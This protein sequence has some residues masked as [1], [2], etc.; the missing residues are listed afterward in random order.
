MRSRVIAIWNRKGGSGKTTTAVNLAAALA[1]RG[2][3]VLLVD[4][5]PQGNASLWIGSRSDGSD[6]LAVLA[7]GRP[8]APLLQATRAPGV[9]LVPGGPL[10][11]QAESVLPSLPGADRR[12]Q[13]ALSRLES[14]D[15]VLLDTPPA[16]GLLTANALE[17]AG[18][19]LI[20]VD[21]SALGLDALAAVLE[22]LRQSARFGCRIAVSG[23][24]V[25]RYG[26]GNNISRDIVAALAEHHPALTLRTVIRENVR[27]RESPSH[28][29]P[30]DA[31]APGSNGALDYAAL[32]EEIASRVPI[33]VG[34]ELAHASA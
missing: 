9:T 12:L 15:Y 11:V 34:E 33:P 5:D 18:E 3:R 17:A 28:G 1:V 4:L 19:V 6:L 23:I 13:A 24:L 7:E 10:L 21:T 26:A 29:L 22:L 14:W 8:I 2:A 27:L 32:A 25:C 20:P 30:I 31:Y 16:G